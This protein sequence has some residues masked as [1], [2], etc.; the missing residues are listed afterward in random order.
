LKLDD[1]TKSSIKSNLEQIKD[2]KSLASTYDQIMK[3]VKGEAGSGDGKGEMNKGDAAGMAKL[4]GAM[5]EVFE[6]VEK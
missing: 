2:A 4:K 3:W 6:G 1:G 5:K